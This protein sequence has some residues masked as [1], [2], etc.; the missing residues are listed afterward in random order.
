MKKGNKTYSLVLALTFLLLFLI[1]LSSTELL[2]V[3]QSD[4]STEYATKYA[5][6]YTTK[7]ATEYV[8]EYAYVPNEKTNDI[9][10]INTT[11]NIVIS[12]LPVRNIPEGVAVNH[13]GTRVYVTNFGNDNDPGNSISIIYTDTDKVT[14]MLVGAGK[15][16][17]PFG[18]TITQDE[19]LY[20]A[21]YLTN[22]VYA[23]N[24]IT[25]YCSRPIQVGS[26]PL[27][28]ATTPNGKWVYVANSGSNSVSVIDTKNETVIDT[29]NVGLYPYGVAVNP[30]GTKVYVTNSNSHNVSI[31]D[32]ATNNV[33]ATVNV[34]NYPHG[35]AVSPDGSKVYVANHCKYVGTVSVINT[36]TNTVTKNISV[37]GYPCGVAVTHDG[38]WVYVTTSGSENDPGS[39]SVINTTTNTV[40]PSRV[41]AGTNPSGLGQFIGSFHE[42]RIETITNLVCSSD[43]YLT[44]CLV[45]KPVTLTAKV[46]TTSQGTKIPS[47]KVIFMDGSTPIG[48]G[49]VES[50]GIATF[51]TS[52]LSIGSYSIRARYTGDTNFRPSTSSPFSITVGT[53]NFWKP[54]F[55]EIVAVLFASIITAFGGFI[56]G[57][58]KK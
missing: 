41:I 49:T 18:V 32:I 42:S 28:V 24:P 52:S 1:I 53:E 44:Q 2:S 46:S 8:A 55:S 29:V 58:K 13:D 36:T 14:N 4:L 43:Q 40:V 25:N 45:G 54:V 21:N 38:K 22:N 16:L 39:V 26:G 30:D 17:K 57:R 31:I 15:G 47:G 10:V 7:Y 56:L 27:G 6:E 23:I 34:T 50:S 35:V 11:T 5:T 3:A 37:D 51:E 19:T 20:V 9:S 12:T 48:N 33:S